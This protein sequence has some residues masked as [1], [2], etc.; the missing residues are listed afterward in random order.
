MRVLLV[1]M[2]SCRYGMSSI[3]DAILLMFPKK[4]YCVMY[5]GDKA[6][7]PWGILDVW[8]S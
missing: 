6:A 2:M 1:I 7:S 4:C 5:H 8:V 3:L